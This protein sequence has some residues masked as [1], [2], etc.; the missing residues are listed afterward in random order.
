MKK[1]LKIT[2]REARKLFNSGKEIFLHTNKLN[3]N[4]SWQN[5]FPV[6][7]DKEHEKSQIELAKFCKKVE[8]ELPRL[9]GPGKP[10]KNHVRIPEFDNVVNNYRYYNCDNERGNVVIYLKEN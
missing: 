6:R 3:W 2:K 1:Y 5:P 9:Y 4:N 7:I 8:A 10:L